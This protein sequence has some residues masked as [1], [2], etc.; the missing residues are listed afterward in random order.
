[1]KKIDAGSW[2]RLGEIAFLT[3]VFLAPLAASRNTFDPQALRTALLEGGALL[4]AATFALK[5]LARGRWEAPS[6]AW[7]TLAPLAFWIAWTLARFAA[8]P[9][10]LELTPLLSLTAAGWVVFI[11]GQWEMGGARPAARLSFWT[12]ATAAIVGAAAVAQKL[13]RTSFLPLDAGSPDQLGSWATVA[14]TLVLALRLDPESSSVRR[15]FSASTAALLGL[16]IGWSGS[17]RG[18]AAFAVGA[19]FYAAVVPTIL[20]TRQALKAAGLALGS[21][22]LAVACARPEFSLTPVWEGAGTIFLWTTMSAAVAVGLNAARMLRERG[23]F[24]EAGYCAAFTAGFGAWSLSSAL[25]LLPAAG[26]GAVV[27]WAAGGVAT[28]LAS[29]SRSRGVVRVWPIPAGQDVRRLMQGP[30]FLLFAGAMLLPGGWLSSDVRYNRAVALLRA[31]NAQAA[32][33]D[34]G[35]VWRGSGVYAP[36]LFLRGHA[37]VELGRPRE[38]LAYYERLEAVAPEFPRLHAQAAQAYAALGDLRGAAAQRRL[39]AHAEPGRVADLLAWSKASRIAG[40]LASAKTAAA[41]AAQLG[42]DDPSVR[43]EMAE[44]ALLERRLNRQ[45][46]LLRRKGIALKPKP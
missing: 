18:V 14:L 2:R 28:G 45:D 20:R 36:S 7:I 30:V 9:N 17:G 37:S 29:L 46:G 10:K 13:S 16:T 32:L 11:V 5:G 15:T 8:A 23:A 22:L 4:L 26:F 39:Q 6:A 12:A 21:A 19:L 34:A 44:N 38:A 40:D 31:G 24:A 3:L 43:A 25:G 41:M 33:A 27:A 1:M 35:H 42:A